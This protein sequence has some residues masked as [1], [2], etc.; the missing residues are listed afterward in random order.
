VIPFESMGASPTTALLMRARDGDRPALEELFARC[1]PR[2]LTLVA[3]G[4]ALP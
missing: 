4:S 3:C 1:V 2:L